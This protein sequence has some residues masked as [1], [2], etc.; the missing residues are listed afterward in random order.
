[1]HK[2]KHI[3]V[4]KCLVLYMY[5]EYLVITFIDLY[6]IT[7]YLCLCLQAVPFHNGHICNEWWPGAI[8]AAP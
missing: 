8:L 2:F 1:M 6:L 7:L 5:I 4:L 3:N